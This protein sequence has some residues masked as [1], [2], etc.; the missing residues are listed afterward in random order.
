VT[1]HAHTH[2]N[3][4]TEQWPAPS[5]TPSASPPDSSV[6][7]RWPILERS[8]SCETFHPSLPPSHIFAAHFSLRLTAKVVSSPAHFSFRL[9]AKV[10]SSPAPLPHFCHPQLATS[11]LSLLA[12]IKTR[13]LIT[14]YIE[15]P[16]VLQRILDTCVTPPYASHPICG[17]SHSDARPLCAWR[18]TCCLCFDS[19]GTCRPVHSNAGR[20]EEDA[21]YGT[22]PQLGGSI[23]H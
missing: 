22:L 2:T 12:P 20:V 14:M 11:H 7:Q 16:G 19:T 3:N 8:V 23:D 1:T 6:W 10:V 17:A 5:R 21:D 9:T 4:H 15:H 13:R 18:D